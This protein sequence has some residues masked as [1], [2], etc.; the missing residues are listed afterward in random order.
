[1]RELITQLITAWAVLIGLDSST[2]LRHIVV[3]RNNCRNFDGVKA[4]G[5]QR[6]YKDIAR[7]SGVQCS[8]ILVARYFYYRQLSLLNAAK[9][10]KS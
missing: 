8:C 4:V 10:E 9:V 3:P 5:G 7:G 2:Q 6:I 1:M